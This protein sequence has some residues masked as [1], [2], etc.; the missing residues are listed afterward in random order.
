MSLSLTYVLLRWLHFTALMMLAGGSIFST[1]LAPGHYRQHL[2]RRFSLLL[3]SSAV[4]ALVSALLLLAVQT[5]LMGE[6]WKD[7]FRVAVW[8]AVLQTRFG[9]VWQWQIAAA[10]TG[11]AAL[12]LSGRAQQGLYLFSAITQLTGLAFTGHA[13]L[14]DG[15]PG[16]FQRTNQA[17]HLIAAAFWAGGLLPVLLVMTDTRHPSLR[18]PA[19]RTLMRFSGFG[20]LAV[21]LVLISG[22]VNALIILPEWPPASFGP[23]SQLLLLKTV[24]VVVMCGVALWNRYWLVPR[25]QQ[26]GT[27]A[28]QKFIRATLAELALAATVLLLVSLFATLEP[29]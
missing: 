26:S 9:E 1:L 10:L 29:A 20:H 27:H 24:L 12:A 14:L 5:G 4:I 23:Y 25:F 8:H 21:A 2:A 16:M 6:G 28:A 17:M 19:I 22:L 11:A 3:G 13:T 15:I 7:I 18:Q